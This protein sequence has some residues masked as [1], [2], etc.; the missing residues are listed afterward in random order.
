MRIRLIRWLF[1]MV[2]MLGMSAA[3]FAGIGVVI[4]V[5]PPALPVYDQPICPG[6]GYFWTPGYWAWGD[7]FDDY[8]WVPGTW[9]LAPEPGF[10]WTP[11]YWGWVNDSYVWYDGWWGPV[12]GF[13][14]GINY[15]FGYFGTGFVGGRWDNGH[16][17]YNT[18]VWHVNTTVIHNVYETRVENVTVN[19]VSFN[20]GNGGVNARPTAAEEA[21]AHERHIGPIAAQ[22]Q[23]VQ[24]AHG[25]P[26]QRASMNQGRP[27]VAATARPGDFKAGAVRASAAGGEY[28]PAARGGAAANRG[29]AAAGGNAGHV[30]EMSPLEKQAAPNTGDSKLDQKYQKQQDKQYAQQQKSRQKLQQQQEKEDQRVAKQNN[31]AAKQQTEQRHQQQTQA[32]QQREQQQNHDMQQ[33]MS[34]PRGG[35]RPP[36]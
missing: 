30:R 25:N 34:A 36:K 19:H 18:A 26:Q 13:Y 15:G 20:G 2:L 14:G 32:L 12:V 3:A 29:G 24:E 16:F 5:G 35:G 31:D 22:T 21:A 27:E 8:Y 23:H 33:R 9:V 1:V 11:G 28:H 7:D 4:T 10:F 6:D 17:F